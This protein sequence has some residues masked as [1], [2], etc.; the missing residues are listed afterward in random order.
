MQRPTDWTEWL[1]THRFARQ[2]HLFVALLLF[3]LAGPIIGPAATEG[4]R[5][6]MYTLL[7]FVVIVG[8]L[9]ASR[10]RFELVVTALFAVGTLLTGVSSAVFES[11]A[12][13][14]IVLGALFFAFVS[15]LI[16]R[17]LFRYTP[18]VN[19][20]TLWMAV[21]LYILTGLFFAFT[22]ACITLI[23][24]DAVVGKFMD[25]PFRDQIYGYIYFS[26]VTLTTLGYG[27]ITPN[28]IAVGAL[29]YVE[30]LFGQLYIAIMVARLVGLYTTNHDRGGSSG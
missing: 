10:N 7:I 29:A 1:I 26:F 2:S 11:V 17:D 30:A 5:L 22:Y 23:Y 15:Y 3:L 6:S 14:S 18:E 16:G 25:L 9:A 28:H 12:A 8:P 19:T 21:N 27:D 20:E 24:P 4:S 13:Y